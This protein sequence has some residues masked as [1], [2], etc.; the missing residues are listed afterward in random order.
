MSSLH[1]VLTTLCFIALCT[2]LPAARAEDGGD[3]AE[4]LP[5]RRVMLFTSGVGFFEHRASVEGDREITLTFEVDD[6]NDLLKS[7][8]VQDLGGGSIAAVTYGS[9]DPVAKAL[10]SFAV[11]LTSN[12]TMAQL[13]ENLRGE[14]VEV[15]LTQRSPEEG[16]V[17]SV[18]TRTIREE[19]G[20]VSQ[21][22]LN[23]LTDKGLV[24]VP[25]DEVRAIRLLDPHLAQEVQQALDTLAQ[26]RDNQKKSVTLS[27]KGE[28][29]RPVRVGYIQETPVWK[30]SYRLVLGDDDGAYLQGWA[31]IENTTNRDWDDV[32]LTLVSGA[33]VSFV[34][35]LY[36]P[37]YAPRPE[38]EPELRPG[39]APQR[40]ERELEEQLR[41]KSEARK[42]ARPQ[43]RGR[44]ADRGFLGGGA[45]P[46][47]AEAASMDDAAWGPGQGVEAGAQGA[48]VG[49]LFQYRI[50]APV[51]LARQRSAMIPIVGEDVKATKL[52]V[53]DPRVHPKHP[54]NGVRLENT[55][56]LHL[57]QGPV[58]VFDGGSYAGDALLGDLAPGADRLLTYAVDLQVEVKAE[59]ESRPDDLV[60]VKVVKGVL[61]SSYS[62]ER[63]TTYLL[64][65]DDDQVRKVVLTQPIESDWKL[66]DPEN[67]IDRTRSDYRPVIE[68]PAK[69]NASITLVEERD[70]GQSIALTNLDDRRIAYFLHAPVVSERIRTALGEVVRRKNAIE[71]IQAQRS[72]AQQ[73][74]K[75]IAEEQDRLRQNMAQIDRNSDLYRRYM[76]KL[77]QQ[78][79]RVEALRSE[80]DQLDT[81]FQEAR[82]ALDA[83]LENLTLE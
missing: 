57:M 75:A 14:R 82:V 63:R 17:V 8:V 31:V 19:E 32:V 44:A 71:A 34:M 78:E 36:E 49:E 38:V 40:Y 59:R 35:N 13:F 21:D 69:G 81:R 60:E 56:S 15:E 18:Q 37:L 5:L 11:D 1:F 43:R 25:F 51:T 26:G 64:R 24:S 66:V 10:Q 33:P 76:E 41:A 28:G 6:I 73:E 54:L 52:S 77:G 58:T 30:T 22:V 23:L 67:A 68:V 53:Y 62:Q 42:D 70:F 4:A 79:D 7:M 16:R 39:V 74:L 45:P 72:R 83:Y 27:F 61:Q 80:L 20:I 50:D 29:E 2:V 46:A 47:P 3:D 12:L 65:N 55:T 9:R 48:E